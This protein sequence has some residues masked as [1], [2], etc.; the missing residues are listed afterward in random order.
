MQGI[1]LVSG[2]I[3]MAMH[4]VFMR[5]RLI[6]RKVKIPK[7]W[8]WQNR[9]LGGSKKE[10]MMLLT[11]DISN[12]LIKTVHR[13]R[14]GCALFLPKTR[15]VQYILWKRSLNYTR[16]GPMYFYVSG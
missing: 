13:L 7:H 4:S 11:G 10:V 16:Y 5:L 12:S 9:H 1:I 14:A 6:I 15:T 8:N 3:P 2:R